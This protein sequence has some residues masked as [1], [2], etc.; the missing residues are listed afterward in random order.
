VAVRET[1]KKGMLRKKGDAVAQIR[2]RVKGKM[3]AFGALDP[4]PDLRLGAD[5]RLSRFAA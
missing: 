5:K 4:S 1:G 3:N 2:R